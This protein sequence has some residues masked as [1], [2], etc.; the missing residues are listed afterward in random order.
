MNTNIIETAGAMAVGS[1]AVLGH[2]LMVKETITAD[3]Y[4]IERQGQKM[5][6]TR[7]DAETWLQGMNIARRLSQAPGQET[8]PES[9][10]RT[11]SAAQPSQQPTNPHK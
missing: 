11:G 1:S 3:S 10:N 5:V 7:E 6:V 8:Q 4:I 2:R 9:E